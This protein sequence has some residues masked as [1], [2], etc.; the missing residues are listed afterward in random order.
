MNAH[1]HLSIVRARYACGVQAEAGITTVYVRRTVEV[2]GH[3]MVQFEIY[4]H[5]LI[6]CTQRWRA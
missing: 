4:Q 6:V 5:R 1:V 2:P 3:G